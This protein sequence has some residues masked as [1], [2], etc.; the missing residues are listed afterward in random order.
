MRQGRWGNALASLPFCA[1]ADGGADP[2]GGV[3]PGFIGT[4]IEYPVASILLRERKK[5]HARG[6]LKVLPFRAALSVGD[7]AAA[8]LSGLPITAVFLFAQRWKSPV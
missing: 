5:T 7:F 6:R 1:V 8:I 2:D 3:H 4:I